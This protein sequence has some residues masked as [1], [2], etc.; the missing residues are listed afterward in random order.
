MGMHA[1]SLQSFS[2]LF[3]RQEYW[4]GLQCPPPGN[5]P[6]RGIEIASLM[7][8]IE[9]ASLMSP[10]LVGGFFSTSTTW[11]IF[12]HITDHGLIPWLGNPLEK[13]M[14]TRY[15]CL[16]NSMDRGVC[17]ATVHGIAKS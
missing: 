4:S 10:A 3:S 7:W 14:A 1:K 13:G 11:V 6:D 5:L 17:W 2:T 12:P 16:E 15:S 9:T 8:G